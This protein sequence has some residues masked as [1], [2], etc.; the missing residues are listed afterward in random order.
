MDK[1]EQDLKKKVKNLKISTWI[2]EIISLGCLS[3]ET[4]MILNSNIGDTTT[5]KLALAGIGF[6]AGVSLIVTANFSGDYKKQNQK[7][8]EIAKTNK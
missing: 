7:L 1:K 2:M 6:Y 5:E 3:G 8:K 4:A